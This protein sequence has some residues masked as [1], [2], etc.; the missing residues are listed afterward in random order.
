MTYDAAVR[1]HGR[2]GAI[3]LACALVLIG[4]KESTPRS[5]RTIALEPCHLDGLSKHALCGVVEVSENPEDPSSRTI[6]LRIAV[7]EASE[8]KPEADSVWFLAGGPGQA[9]TEAFPPMLGAFEEIGRDRDIVLVDIRGTGSSTALDCQT[10]DSLQDMIR[11][12]LDLDELDGCLAQLPGD[13]VHHTTRNVV[14]DLDVVRA[15]LGYEQINLIGGSYGTRLAL[16]Y[17][18]HHGERVRTLVLDGVAPPQMA[19]PEGFAV[20]AQAAF[21]ALVADCEADPACA[22]AFP[23]VAGDLERALQ[24]LGDAEITVAVEHPR[25][26][27]IEQ[28]TVDRAAVV[29]GLRGILYVPQLSVLLPLLI[30]RAADGDFGPLLGQAA[31]FGDAMADSMSSGLTLSILCAEDLPRIEPEA[32]RT[33]DRA[34]FLGPTSYDLLAQACTHWPHA[35]LPETAGEPVRSDAPTLL[36]S[37]AVDPVTPPRWAELAAETLPNSVH[38]IV[39][40]TGHGT[41]TID[42]VT[43]QITAFIASADPSTVD[44]SCVDDIERPSFFIDFAGPSH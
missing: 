20:D 42:C 33:R 8:R 3:G 4:C 37:G 15:A 32:Q 19:L 2:A 39:P 12:Q 1:D 25:T 9:A 43:D 31:V 41:M 7:I 17:A 16:E 10:S 26:G 14:E 13:P 27:A 6:P 34:T 40:N 24:R 30:H 38:V 36:L 18:R 22:K 29:N 11:S 35:P 23:D 5:T 21:D 28:L 44:G